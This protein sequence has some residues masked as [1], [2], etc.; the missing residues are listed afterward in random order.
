MSTQRLTITLPDY[1]HDW[2]MN[3]VPARQVSQFVSKALEEKI[4]TL[5]RTRKNPID[6]F[7]ALRKK[8][9]KI[10]QKEIFT[11]IEKDRQ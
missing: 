10:S 7:L 6:E 5:L 11:A 4:L 8:T 1:L 3:D 2:L 9:P